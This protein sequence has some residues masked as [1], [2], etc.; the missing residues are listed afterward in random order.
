LL[1][2]YGGQ[3]PSHYYNGGIYTDN[4][5]ADMTGD[6]K[7]ELKYGRFP[8]KTVQQCSLM[9]EKAMGYERTP[10]L[11]DTLWFRTGLTVVREDYD[12]DDTIYWDNAHLA[13]NYMNENGFAG[14]DTLSLA[15]GDSAKH[16]QSSVSNGKSFVMY[17]GVG[18]VNWWYPF[19]V[20][21][22]A[23]TNGSMLPVVLSGT[24]ETVTLAP[25]ESMVG[26][27]WLRAGTV[28]VPKGAVAFFG[29]THAASHV[30]GQRGAVCR[31]FMRAYF[32][33]SV[34][35]LGEAALAGKAQLDTEYHDSIEYQGFNLLGDPTL[36]YWTAKPFAVQV[37]CDS[38]VT[39]GA[40]DFQVLVNKAGQPLKNCVVCARKDTEVY[41][42]G[43]TDAQGSVTLAI[44]PSTPGPMDVTVTGRN[45]LPYEGTARVTYG[46][47]GV[48]AIVEPDT[49]IP[50]GSIAPEVRVLNC[51]SSPISFPVVFR[52]TDSAGAPVYRD[53][54]E[55]SGLAAGETLQ[56]SFANWQ[57]PN[58]LYVVTC[59]TQLAHDESPANDTLS[60]GVKVVTHDVGVSRILA[61]RDSAWAGDT[62]IP[63]AMVHNY[64]SVSETFDVF[65]SVFS[66]ESLP[67][68]DYSDSTS[69]TVG[70]GDSSS[71]SF[72]CW[73][74]DQVGRFE[75]ECFTRLAADP[76]PENDTA[77]ETLNVL[78][79]VGIR[80]GKGEIVL[81]TDVRVMQN[82]APGRVVLDVSL[83]KPG[84]AELVI[85]DASGR[86]VATL[87][88][89]QE[90]EGSYR[91]IWSGSD[92]SGRQLASGLYFVRLATDR[93]VICRKVVLNR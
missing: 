37:E 87:L 57:A 54:Q 15:Q 76:Y 62:V 28:A 60:R 89:S 52:I 48:T 40:G 20:D 36:L 47:A 18:T 78:E 92:Q 39:V 55:V 23:M 11:D 75:V 66:L 6:Y 82:P 38:V 53:S 17:R 71:V 72:S 46:D 83:S 34:Q 16:V 68:L 21:P 49:L 12:S 25:N 22:G 59:S 32:A 29:N 67:G 79:H 77:T 85:L 80:T 19:W 88:R 93:R 27:A 5:Y 63:Q 1:V 33:D 14:F 31:G 84:R 45:V 61:P 10:F 44:N 3:V 86:R 35:T 70:A 58:G 91:I 9:V 41:E 51:G 26:D 24:C 81:T 43:V 73:V 90:P 8:C 50:S 56:V 13:M 64:G 4:Y 42:W 69:T 30:A 74:P 7:A 65:C 2:G